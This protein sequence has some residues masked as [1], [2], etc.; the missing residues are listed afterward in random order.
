M[1]GELGEEQAFLESGVTAA[2][3]DYLVCALVEGTVAGGAEVDACTDEVFFT[4]DAGAAVRGAGGD[5]HSSS[6][7]LLAR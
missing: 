1:L 6:A 5:E 2:E 7:N 4:V 3:D